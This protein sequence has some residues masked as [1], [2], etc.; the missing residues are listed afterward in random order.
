METNN[1]FHYRVWLTQELMTRQAKNPAYSLRAFASCLGISP[2]GLSQM[3]SGNRPMSRKAALKII[4][5]CSFSPEERQL[6]LAS[7]FGQS[8]AATKRQSDTDQSKEDILRIQVDIFKSISDWHHS[9]ILCLGELPKN[10]RNPQWIASRLG[11]SSKAAEDAYDRLLRLQL[12]SIE[13]K[14]FRKLN[15]QIFIDNNGLSEP[16]IRNY[17]RQ[18]LAKAVESLERDS[19]DERDFSS[20]TMA[21]DESRL[22]DARQKIKEFRRE[23]CRFLEGGKRTRVFTLAVQLFPVSKN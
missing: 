2:T 16:A 1:Q 11:I 22:S 23:L 20:M 17:H 5:R 3:M 7:A 6:F 21:I 15:R 8:D 13:G 19:V 12:I 10:E 9:A 4:E 14:G 18:N